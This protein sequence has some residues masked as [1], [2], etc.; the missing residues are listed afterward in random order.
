[1]MSRPQTHLHTPL[2]NP[3]NSKIT[4]FPFLSSHSDIGQKQ[5]TRCSLTETSALELKTSV[6]ST[7]GTFQATNPATTGGPKGLQNDTNVKK[8]KTRTTLSV[9]R[10]L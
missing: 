4:V 9:L 10:L 1:M 7:T 5:D 3:S 2:Q 6:F 8:T